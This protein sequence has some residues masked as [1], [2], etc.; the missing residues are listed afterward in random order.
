MHYFL[1]VTNSFYKGMIILRAVMF[2]AFMSR[3]FSSR[4]RRGNRGMAS[5][6]T[7]F[8]KLPLLL[9][10]LTSPSME[11]TPLS[12]KRARQKSANVAARSKAIIISI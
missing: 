4:A 8:A 9:T 6:V 7:A 2:S 10:P 1:S 12:D 5:S 11:A 3:L